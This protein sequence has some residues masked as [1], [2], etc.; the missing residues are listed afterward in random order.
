MFALTAC[1]G[2]GGS[3]THATTT[4]GLVSAP[5]TGGSAV[6]STTREPSA[7]A[8]LPVVPC[9][10]SYGVE[11]SGQPF[12]P[13]QLP[14][15]TAPEG[16]SFYSNGR[17]TV[18]AP[19]G[20]ACSALVAADGG[21]RL[22]VY[23]P[24]QADLST[25][26]VPAGTPVVQLD[27]EWTGHGPGA[28]LICP[29]FPKSPAATFLGDSLPCPAAPAAEQVTQLTDDVVAFRDTAGV[30]GTGAGSGG[31]LASTGDAVYPQMSPSPQGGVTVDLL[32]CTLP[33]ALADLCRFSIELG[34]KAAS[35]EALI[36]WLPGDEFEAARK[37]SEEQAKK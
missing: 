27:G 21:Q 25:Q 2:S 33:P 13:H 15:A 8:V 22:D 5:T 10:T 28:Q 35:Q 31:R 23:E 19:A 29:L 14:A 24:G 16:V 7:P 20:W 26:E 12:V 17:L 9:S 37:T 1:T 18:L 30:R 32:S 34:W 6:A 3:A 4:A 36:Q 11:P